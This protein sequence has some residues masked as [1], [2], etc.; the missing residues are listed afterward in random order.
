MQVAKIVHPTDYITVVREKKKTF[1]AK[2]LF[3][4]HL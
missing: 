3:S 4:S 1:S 2:F